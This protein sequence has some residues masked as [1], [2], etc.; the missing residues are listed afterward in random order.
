MLMQ[1]FLQRVEE[2]AADRDAGLLTLLQCEPPDDSQQASLG[3]A[4]IHAAPLIMSVW[5]RPGSLALMADT[6]CRG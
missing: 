3:H 6:A 5:S 1:K 2:W 4:A